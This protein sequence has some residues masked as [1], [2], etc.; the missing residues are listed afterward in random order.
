MEDGHD[1]WFYGLWTTCC[2]GLEHSQLLWQSAE[3]AEAL[4]RSDLSTAAA[5]TVTERLNNRT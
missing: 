5:G 4:V 3:V 2:L 1:A